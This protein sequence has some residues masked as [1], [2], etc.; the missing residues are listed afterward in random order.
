MQDPNVCVVFRP[1]KPLDGNFYGSLG[2]LL[3]GGRALLASCQPYHTWRVAR[4]A[5]EF[6]FV[7]EVS[8]GKHPVWAIFKS[9]YFMGLINFMGLMNFLPFPV[10]ETWG[11]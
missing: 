1:L 3:P 7:L 8:A 4:V 2:L 9:L 11:L 10:V 6:S 5:R